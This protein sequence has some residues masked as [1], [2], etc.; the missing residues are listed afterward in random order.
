MQT[1]RYLI[2]A[3]ALCLSAAAPIKPQPVTPLQMSQPESADC[4]NKLNMAPGLDG[5]YGL[6]WGFDVVRMQTKASAGP[7]V[8]CAVNT[9]R[10]FSGIKGNYSV[11]NWVT[12]ATLNGYSDEQSFVSTSN[13]YEYTDSWGI[14]LSNSAEV[15]TPYGTVS[16]SYGIGIGSSKSGYSTSSQA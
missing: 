8:N 14:D 4:L 9:A 13:R 2:F 10:R 11:P 12:T 6:A 5:A 3:A 1:S 7:L 16:S 15:P